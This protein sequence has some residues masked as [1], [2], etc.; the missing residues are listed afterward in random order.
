MKTELD[1]RKQRV[2][3]DCVVSPHADPV[4]DGPVLPH[5]LRELLLD[6]EGLVGRLTNQN[7]TNQSQLQFRNNQMKG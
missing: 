2:E 1:L 7:H 4:G 5:F 6:P 3:P